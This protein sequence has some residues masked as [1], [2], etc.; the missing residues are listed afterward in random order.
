ML[1]EQEAE[2]GKS[3]FVPPPSAGKRKRHKRSSTGRHA[4]F[5]AYSTD[6]AAQPAWL[7]LNPSARI[8]Y[9][10]IEHRFNGSNNGKIAAA[11]RCLSEATGISR[12]AVGDALHDLQAK[13]YVKVA[14]LGSFGSSGGHAA[15]YTLTRITTTA[16]RKGHHAEPGTR[17]YLSWTSTAEYAVKVS[18]RQSASASKRK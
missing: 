14:R 10:A 8:I 5:F 12:G 6:F 2:A 7:A 3:S 4:R 1:T 18:P 11:T 17:C 15:L 13:G 16:N 9:M